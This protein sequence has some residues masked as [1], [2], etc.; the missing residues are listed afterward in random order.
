[1][2]DSLLGSTNTSGY[3]GLLRNNNGDFLLGFYGAAANPSILLAEL[4]TI[5]HGLQIC[6]DKGFRRIVCFSDSL[7][8]I[9]LIR[10]GVSVHHRFAN[11][12]FSIRQLLDRDWE[13]V[14]KHT[15]RQ[16]NAFEDELA[17]KVD[18]K[19]KLFILFN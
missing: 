6:W 17:K 10:D 5:L 14:I 1:V 16:G 19:R 15:L 4:M 9:N 13:V 3:G 7:Q 18:T 12:V 8:T 11:E 2:D